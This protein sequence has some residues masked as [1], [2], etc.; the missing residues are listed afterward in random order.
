MKNMKNM[1]NLYRAALLAALGLGTASVASA[2]NLELGFNDNAV[3]AAQN[4][5]VIN[6]GALSQFTQTSSLNLSSDFS[7]STFTSAYT[8]DGNALNDVAVGAV[9]G[10]SS[11]LDSF[12]S[13]VGI[14][15]TVSANN[16]GSSVE[17]SQP[18]VGEYA[19]ATAGG[20][21]YDVAVAPNLPGSG[22]AGSIS[23]TS[24]N[25]TELLSSGVLTEELYEAYDTGSGRSVTLNEEAL[26]YLTV[27]VNTDSIT[28]A[29][30]DA[31]PEPSTY[32][33]LAGAG[34][35]AVAFRRQVFP[36]NA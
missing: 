11:T 23:S 34:L 16:I 27:N 36:K 14:G 3:V 33:L 4:D 35:L 24:E 18:T 30:I 19:S 31:V 17:F 28:Y 2:Q 10:I 7:A 5:Y 1:K 21:S 9:G 29:G 13:T 12:Y 25:P 20:W 32:G 26:G 6:L 15:P 22:P 8:G